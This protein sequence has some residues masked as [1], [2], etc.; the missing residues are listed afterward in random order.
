MQFLVVMIFPYPKYHAI[1][2]LNSI[3]PKG[4]LET[5]LSATKGELEDL[6]LK[7]T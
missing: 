7:I 5:T 3:T 6:K 4:D 1:L 2:R